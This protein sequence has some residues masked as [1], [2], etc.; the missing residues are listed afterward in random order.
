MI[1]GWWTAVGLVSATLL[2]QPLA[3]RA[4]DGRSTLRVCADPNNLPFSNQQREGFENGL[5]QLVAGELGLRLEYHWAAQRRGFIRRGLGE[6][7]CDVLLGVPAELDQALPTRPYY[8]STYVFVSRADDPRIVSSLDDPILRQLRVGV[9]LVGDDYHNTP[10]AD[11]LARRRM[12][13]NL[14]GFSIYGDYA[15]P[16]PPARIVEAVA[17]RKIDVAIVWGPFAGYFAPRQSVSLR[18]TPMAPA[19]D[20]DDPPFTFAIAMAVR[21]GDPAL[22]DRLDAVLDRRRADVARLLDRYGVP[23]VQ[24]DGDATR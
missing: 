20:G 10:P 22:R 1:G 16:N 17:N 11:A 12:V 7:A 4:P 13:G 15:R 21:N 23:R 6:G 24:E 8:R 18:I 5:A 14:V 3:A 9:H 2:L 19:S